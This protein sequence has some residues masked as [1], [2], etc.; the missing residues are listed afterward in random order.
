MAHQAGSTEP[1]LSSMSSILSDDSLWIL[2]SGAT[3][4]MVC[5]SIALTQS[6][7]IYGH[8]V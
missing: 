1:S 7:P 2:D 6:Y 3:D 8:I 4:H 5:S